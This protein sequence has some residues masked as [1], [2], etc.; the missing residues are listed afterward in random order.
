M[1]KNAGNAEILC[2]ESERDDRRMIREGGC[3]AGGRT[4][5][6]RGNAT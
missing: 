2:G 4:M 1:D 5:E 3:C 6:K